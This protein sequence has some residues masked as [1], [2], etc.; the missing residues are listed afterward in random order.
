MERLMELPG[1]KRLFEVCRRLNLQTK[2]SPPGHTPP[3]AGTLMSGLP[4]DPLL[5]AVYAQLGHAAF[6]TDVAGIILRRQDD[7]EQ[8]LEEDNQWWSEAYRDQLAMPTLIFAGEPLMAYHY[9]TVPSLA[10]DQGLQPVVKV[11]AYEDLYALPVASSVDGFFDAYSRYLE[12]LLELPEAREEGD[13]SLL[14]PR[15]V[16]HII[17]RDRR[18]VEMM[19]D[20]RFAQFTPDAEEQEWMQQVMAAGSSG[21]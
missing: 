12:A 7:D 8:K 20:G 1:L 5:A 18:L 19:R 6:A 2:F 3:K 21:M 16:P 10:D 11:S 14:F 17:G 4:L 13:T 9:A 15:H